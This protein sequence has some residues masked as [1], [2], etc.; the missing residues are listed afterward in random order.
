M[1]KTIEGCAKLRV[2]RSSLVENENG[3]AWPGH[4]ARRYADQPSWTARRCGVLFLKPTRIAPMMTPAE[5]LQ[6]Y[7]SLGWKNNNDPM[8]QVLALRREDPAA[9]GELVL[10]FLDSGQKH[11]TFIDTA[12]DLM[13]DASYAATLRRVW[14]DA[15]DGKHGEAMEEVLDSA[16]LQWP[17]LYSGSWEQLLAAT[18]AEAGGPRYADFAWRAMDAPRRMNGWTAWM[19]RPTKRCGAAAPC[20]LHA[21]LPDVTL[22]A[23]RRACARQ[24]DMDQEAW[25]DLLGYALEEGGLRPLHDSRPLHISASAAQRRHMDASQPAWRRE[26]RALHPTWKRFDGP[27]K[28]ATAAQQAGMGGALPGTCGL[29]HGPL[30]RL[31]SL[32]QPARAGVAC[33][34][35]LSFGVC[36]SCLGWEEST[37][38][39]RHD[40]EGL[41]QAH[42]TQRKDVAIEPQ[43]PAEPLASAEVT[44]FEAPARWAWQ[45][46]GDSNGQQNLSR[47]GGAPSWVQQAWYPPCP[48]CG[49]KMPFAF[50][51][52]SDLPQDDGNEWMWAAAVA[53]TVSGA[54][55]AASADIS[56]SAPSPPSRGCARKKSTPGRMA[57]AS[58]A[59]GRRC[60]LAVVRRLHDRPSRHIR[61]RRLAPIP[62][63]AASRIDRRQACY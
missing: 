19:A 35:P 2:Y 51:L 61:T 20:L 47:V 43:F 54:R 58:P 22:E 34:G 14:Q 36:L 28:D 10:G 27:G 59:G 52:D 16:A 5:I 49:H 40:A 13:D 41:P 11:S 44:L 1:L 42:P 62:R 33:D 46:W 21:R 60:I 30:H 9:L 18:R 48:D 4:A 53:T 26:I 12:L 63:R 38:F 15:R 3:N 7:A 23:W 55:I 50:Q 37:L 56:G 24:P 17:E 25:M 57:R 45:D 32:D 8:A 31:L 6:A 39:Y 29:C